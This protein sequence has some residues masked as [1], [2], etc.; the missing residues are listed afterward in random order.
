MRIDDLA[1][2][3][4]A[5]D[6]AVG[7]AH[8]GGALVHAQQRIVSRQ[9]A[10]DPA[11]DLAVIADGLAFDDAADDAAIHV[12]HVVA[13]DAPEQATLG[14]HHHIDGF[15]RQRVEQAGDRHLAE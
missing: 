5:D 12:H 7:I 4:L 11:H 8:H 14:I 13:D 6:V 3:D 10:N 2:Y 15:R 9:S 1:V